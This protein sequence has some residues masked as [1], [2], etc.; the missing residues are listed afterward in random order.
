MMKDMDRWTALHKA[1]FNGASVEVV[2]L[3]LDVGGEDLIAMKDDDGQTALDRY[4]KLLVPMVKALIDSNP[5][6]ATTHNLIKSG[7]LDRLVKHKRPDLYDKFLTHKNNLLDSELETAINAEILEFVDACR[8]KSISLKKLKSIISSK[9]IGSLFK[10]IEGMPEMA[11][12]TLYDSE[13]SFDVINH[14]FTIGAVE[15]FQNNHQD[16]CKKLA[17]YRK[18][19]LDSLVY[20]AAT[21]GG[22]CPIKR[23]RLAFV[24]QGRSGKSSTIAS[25]SGE[26]FDGVLQSTAGAELVD[27]NLN[28]RDLGMDLLE[29]NVSS[30]DHDRSEGW[31]KAKRDGKGKDRALRAYLTSCEG[32]LKSAS[33]DNGNSEEER[34]RVEQRFREK[35]ASNPMMKPVE[36]ECTSYESKNAEDNRPH[37]SMNLDDILDTA[38]EPAESRKR[39]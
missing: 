1:C 13:P 10:K 3:L 20:A 24:G 35:Y 17:S 16:I 12:D 25:I 37:L 5:S 2:K 34:K 6:F 31:K 7:E 4:G 26:P 8:S 33:S 38:V 11:I 14:L 19:K 28:I 27:I 29:V 15:K 18:H 9:G 22:A 36:D 32:T 39:K 23:G 21:S 30:N